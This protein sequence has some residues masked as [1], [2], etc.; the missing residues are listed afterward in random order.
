[1]RYRQAHAAKSG[2]VPFALRGPK[3]LRGAL[4]AA[5]AMAV[6]LVG[7]APASADA[8]PTLSI[9]PPAGPVTEAGTAT[10]TVRASAVS[11]VPIQVKWNVVDVTPASGHA[12]ASTSADLTGLLSGTATIDAGDTTA[13][14]AV[15]TATDSLFELP[16]DFAVEISEPTYATLG[17]PTKAT[18]TIDDDDAEPT[19]TITPA[20]TTVTEGNSG[21]RQ[22]SFTAE[23]SAVAGTPIK[24]DWSTSASPAGIGNAVPGK[25]FVASKGALTF[26]A[27]TATQTF[28]VDIIGD[29]IDE[30]QEDRTGP[31]GDAE[32]FSIVVDLTTP[33][34]D[35]QAP[36]LVYITDDDATPTVALDDLTVP[37]DDETSAVLAPIK[38]SNASDRAVTFTVATSPGA[39]N[40][41]S[42]LVEGVVGD[43]DFAGLSTTAT[44]APES[45][46]GYAATLVNGDTTFEPNETVAL[47][48]TPQADGDGNFWVT[49]QTAD[50]AT[51]TLNNDDKAPDLAV[52]DSSGKEGDT[53]DVL[54]TVTGISQDAT[55]LT[56]TFTG[57]AAKGHRAASASDFVPPETKT[58]VIDAGTL[59]G[60]EL[61]VPP[62]QVKLY[63]DTEAEPAETIVVSGAGG[64]TGGTVTD[65]VIVIDANDG[66]QPAKP[67]ISAPKTIDGPGTAKIT[68]KVGANE[69]VRLLAAPVAATKQ[70]LKQIAST[71]ADSTG[72]YS[73]SR[74]IS[75]GYRFQTKSDEGA[76]SNEVTVKV[77]Q[78][79]AFTATSGTKGKLS[80]KVT[81]DP[82]LSGRSVV[83]ERYSG[84][85]WASTSWKGNTNASGVWSSTVSAKAG[86]SWTL[87]ARVGGNSSV[88]VEAGLSA[89]KK[90]T[91]K[92]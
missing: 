23:L 85:K 12:A 16:E 80:L 81:A 38:L 68:G 6:G 78:D 89:N 34:M 56:L 21:T 59:P 20:P 65:G 77:M 27:G 47:T 37:E 58:V 48:T 40:P 30:G 66:Y 91:V 29:T 63:D 39:V 42:N 32:E 17:T 50:S 13:E 10:F 69:T 71:K 9:E 52:R 62:L 4:L 79:P 3:S 49:P 25:D 75:T 57:S 44:I 33:A 92:K 90:V 61:P 53:V 54:G 19:V 36:V 83:V 5:V 26:P 7:A 51:L 14:I 72:A 87:R 43:N 35:A 28:T 11:D 15:G 84:G 67:T 18:A 64:A 2:S 24:A 8:L 55:T 41:A 60:T 86:S 1:M 74:A 88:G 82:K 73:F 45:T 76:T 46:T 22:Q 70:P 31:N